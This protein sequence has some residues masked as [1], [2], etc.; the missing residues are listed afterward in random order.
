MKATVTVPKV[1]FPNY[2]CQAISKYAPNTHAAKLWMEF[3]YSDEGQTLFLKGY[4]HPI[5]YA[6]LAKRGK[7]PA[8]IAKKLP[9][10]SHYKNLKFASAAQLD[11]AQTVLNNE[12]GSKM[13]VS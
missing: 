12:W 6:D 11:K 7:I 3:L 2:Y 8:S 1:V 9:S 4:A 10:A 5:R 13:G